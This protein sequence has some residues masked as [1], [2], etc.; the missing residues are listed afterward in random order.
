MKE[1][2]SFKAQALDNTS[3]DFYQF[4]DELLK[5]EDQVARQQITNTISDVSRNGDYH[6]KDDGAELI[7]AGRTFLAQVS[8][9]ERDIAGRRASIVCCGEFAGDEDPAYQTETIIGA[10]H[11]FATR[12]GRTVESTHLEAVRNQLVDLKKK[13]SMRAPI[14]LLG[15]IVSLMIL[16]AFLNY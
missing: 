6:L 12:I 8:C 13:R 2:L 16:I 3:P 11:T 9:K 1:A 14:V 10:I 7:V 5:P 15:L 4:G